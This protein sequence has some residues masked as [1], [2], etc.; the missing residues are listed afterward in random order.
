[1]TGPEVRRTVHRLRVRAAAGDVHRLLAGLDDWPR[2]FPSFV[3]L[4]RL[5]TH[6][7]AERVGMWAL[8]G[9]PGP[10]AAGVEHWVALRRVDDKARRVEFRPE[11]VAPPLREMTRTWVVEPAGEGACEVRLEHAFRLRE[12]DP[13]A[14][15]AVARTAGEIARRELAAVRDAAELAAA[16]PG[17]LLTVEDTVTL[18][19]PAERVYAVLRD[20]AGWPAVMAHVLRADVRESGHGAHLL[21][22]ETLERRGGTFTT[23]TARVGVPHRRIAYKQLLLPPL[24][25]SHHVCW[26]LVPGADGGTAVVS[27]QTVVLHEP[28]VAAVLGE[29]T[30]LETARGFVRDELSS[31]VRLILDAARQHLEYKRRQEPADSAGPVERTS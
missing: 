29:G 26:D 25:S 13:E 24:G 30:D 1:M 15:G 18:G 20:A 2:V 10:E 23:R 6:G 7:D 12:D 19:A 16:S 21:E 22:M 3:H 28:G 14:A 5:G 31:K 17:L 9:E 27:R 11:E 4:E 8:A